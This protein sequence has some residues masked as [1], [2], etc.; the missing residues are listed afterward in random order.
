M[1]SVAGNAL[2]ATNCLN[3]RQLMIFY[4]KSHYSVQQLDDVLAKKTF[5]D[6]I[7]AWDPA[8]LYFLQSDIDS[9]KKKYED[10]F[11]V[12]IAKANCRA[13][14]SVFALYSKRF[15]EVQNMIQKHLKSSFDLSKEEFINLDRKKTKPSRSIQEISE[16]WRKRIKLQYL[17]LSEVI[18]EDKKIKTKLEKRFDLV[19]KRHDE[20]SMDDVYNTYLDIFAS[21]MDPHSDYF[22]PTQLEDF[23]INTRLS[24]EGI[25]AML[26]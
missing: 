24:L 2:F 23:R 16:R 11:R 26:Q 14:D 17:N 19:R 9:L 13:I 18:K 6:F 10:S 21:A 8:K 12:D 15:N 3:V 4:L 7:K 22:P 25:G 1:L 5:N 20:L